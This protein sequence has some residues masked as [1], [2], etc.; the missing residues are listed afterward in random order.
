MEGTGALVEEELVVELDEVVDELE[1]D[2]V[3][4]V[5]LDEDDELEEVVDVVLT[6]EEVVDTL[7]TEV[8]GV[9]VEDV[10]VDSAA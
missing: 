10:F 3:V 5:E 9:V 2:E 7:L 6:G 1:E 4:E 8:E